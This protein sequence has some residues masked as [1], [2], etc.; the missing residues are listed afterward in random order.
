MR[1]ARAIESAWRA[2]SRQSLHDPLADLSV[3]RPPSG[4]A[5]RV[6]TEAWGPG[7]RGRRRGSRQDLTRL[8]FSW[9][10]LPLRSHG[11]V[12]SFHGRVSPSGADRR[13]VPQPVREPGQVRQALP[14]GPLYADRESAPLG[15]LRVRTR[16]SSASNAVNCGSLQGPCA[17]RQFPTVAR[18]RRAPRGA[19]LSAASAKA[20]K[21]AH[22][23]SLHLARGANLGSIS[24]QGAQRRRRD[25][26][27][28]GEESNPRPVAWKTFRS[29]RNSAYLQLVA[30]ERRHTPTWGRTQYGRTAPYGPGSSTGAR[31]YPTER[32]RS[33]QVCAS[34]DRGRRCDAT[35]R[36][37]REEPTAVSNAVF[38]F[39]PC[40]FG[41]L[42]LRGRRAVPL[43]RCQVK[44][45]DNRSLLRGEIDT[46]ISQQRE[47]SFWAW[48]H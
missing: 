35:E 20:P 33:K 1:A 18:Q 8:A 43:R 42:S 3:H 2:S 39:A 19:S 22:I 14:N 21:A 36:H 38:G 13:G 25:A 28:P 45:V 32:G 15:H 27:R 30:C 47:L 24:A 48:I 4:S 17:H 29:A 44:W 7:G 40:P 31:V 11:A 34:E 6:R 12:Q 16:P 9:K 10:A 26:W 5:S 46:S 41:G 23:A 37:F